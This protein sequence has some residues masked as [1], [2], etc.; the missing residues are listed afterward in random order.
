MKRPFS[1]FEAKFSKSI[2][3]FSAMIYN[4]YILS[5]KTEETMKPTVTIEKLRQGGF[6]ETLKLLYGHDE[7]IINAQINRYIAAIESFCKLYPQR[8]DIFLFSAPGRTEV[9]GNHTDH[10][11]GCVFA[12]AVNLDVIAVVSFHD[13]GIIR[14][15]SKGHKAN[16]IDLSQ[17]N[18][19]SRECG[20][21]NAIIRGIASKFKEK[22]VKIS[23]FDAYTT[24]DVLSGSGLSSSAA[25]EVLIGTII[26]KHYNNGN[27]GAVE[28]AKIGQYAENAYFGKASGLMD[29]TVSSVGGFVYIDFN[30]TS[31]PI[32]KTCN[33]DFESAGHCLCITDTKGSHA[34]LTD[35]YVSIPTEMK[36]IAAFFGKDNLRQTDEDDFYRNIS[37]IR[38]NCSDRAIMRAAHFFDEN[39]RAGLEEKALSAG[40]F[41]QFLEI[42]KSSG[43]SSADLLQNLY[44]PK[45]PLNQEIPLAI[46]MS[47]HILKDKGAVRV[48][49]G[50]FAGTI[51]AFVPIELVKD[52]SDCMNSIFGDGSCHVLK[53]RL[54]GGFAFDMEV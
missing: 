35:D 50:G 52:Y 46:M 21:S 43:E 54:L 44:S 8:E 25:F 34:D 47:K 5:Q 40:K 42:V 1:C 24:S 48:H 37:N 2:D 36:Q 13:E 12:A 19:N 3:F 27:A 14:L 9:G 20:T 17:L 38:K 16:K 51:Q 26:D 6:N 31:A 28:I 23:G 10:Q 41:D 22:G 33:F 49:G 39:K 53:I 11:N 32:I 18:A 45:N 29:Q 7:N 4:V 15:K 30:N